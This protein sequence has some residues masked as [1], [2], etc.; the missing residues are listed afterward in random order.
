[1]AEKISLRIS[2]EGTKQTILEEVEAALT[3]E[4]ARIAK[5]VKRKVKEYDFD[6]AI[7]KIIAMQIPSM[8]QMCFER[9][10]Q[11]TVYDR[12]L[13]E[14]ITDKFKVCILDAIKEK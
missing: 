3:K 8:L 11:H 7:E 12:E 14:L 5:T 13:E 2:L 1:M 6:K 10:I 9:A 4:E